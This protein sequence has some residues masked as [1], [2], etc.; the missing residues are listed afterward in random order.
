LDFIGGQRVK[1]VIALL[2][3]AIMT[4]VGWW[5]YT[6]WERSAPKSTGWLTANEDMR[7]LLLKQSE[8]KEKKP[9]TAQTDGKNAEASKKSSADTTAEKAKAAESKPSTT[10]ADGKTAVVGGKPNAVQAVAQD[11]E[12]APAA[13]AEADDTAAVSKRDPLIAASTDGGSGEPSPSG[14]SGSSSQ[15][16]SAKPTEVEMP[17]PDLAVGAS[18]SGGSAAKPGQA[19]G[20]IQ[21]NKATEAQLVTIPGIGESKAKAI[22]AHRKQIGRF[23][24][25]EQLLDVK[26]IGEKL[27]EK[28]KP[29]VAVEP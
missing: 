15:P 22:I 23:Q 13:Q 19:K 3:A 18:A 26:G 6:V 29:Y 7:Q 28:M 24:T 9:G 1:W 2:V 25:M 17:K 12:P 8:E 5:G 14:P 20:K 16:S 11:S 4:V 10:S 27:L 21:L